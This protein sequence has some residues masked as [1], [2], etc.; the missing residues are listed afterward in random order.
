L[1]GQQRE[2]F[3]APAWR[4]QVC[5]VAAEPGWWAETVGEHFAD[6]QEAAPLAERLGFTTDCRNW[7]VTR[8]STGE[9]QRLALV[10]T[11]LVR[12]RILLLDEPTS[13]LD[14][15]AKRDV[16]LLLA[17]RASAGVSLLWVTHDQ[18][19]ARRVASRIL[20]ME[21]GRVRAKS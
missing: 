11:L 1:D 4:R 3:F 8:L 12:P 19:Q 5:Y 6:W 9:R 17:E 7:S 21:H 2:G 10:R 20:V 13:G 15:K 18:A 14:E 16:E